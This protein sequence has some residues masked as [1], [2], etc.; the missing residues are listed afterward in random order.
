MKAEFNQLALALFGLQFEH[1]EP[2]RRF[3]ETRRITPDKI[4]LWSD[5]PPILSAAFKEFDLSSLPVAE[6]TTVFHSSGTTEQRPSRHFHNA[7][8]LAL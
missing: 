6:R 5:I 7:A 4:T 3:C 2:Y 1:V 8:S